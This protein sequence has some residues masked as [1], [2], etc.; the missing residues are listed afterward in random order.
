[1]YVVESCNICLNRVGWRQLATRYDPRLTN[2]H[3][4]Q[5]SE[6]VDMGKLA[7]NVCQQAKH[8]NMASELLQI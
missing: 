5:C 3:I 1:M 4:M 7:E 6:Q 2:A 8:G